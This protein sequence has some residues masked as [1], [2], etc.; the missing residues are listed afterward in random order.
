MDAH[1]SAREGELNFEGSIAWPA[2]DRPARYRLDPSSIVR[3]PIDLELRHL[4]RI[5]AEIAPVLGRDSD[6]QVLIRH[7]RLIGASASQIDDE[8]D[9]ERVVAS[10]RETLHALA[11]GGGQW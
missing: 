2:A 8:S 1:G 9:R 10:M 7:A 4:L 11:E 5:I 3:Q 6:R